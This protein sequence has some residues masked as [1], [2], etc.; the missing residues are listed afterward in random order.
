MIKYEWIIHDLIDFFPIC[1]NLKDLLRKTSQE[2]EKEEAGKCYYMEPPHHISINYLPFA[3]QQWPREACVLLLKQREK[4]KISLKSGKTPISLSGIR[5]SFMRTLGFKDASPVILLV[6]TRKKYL[7]WAAIKG[8]SQCKHSAR[9]LIDG[10][11]SACSAHPFP[12]S[13]ELQVPLSCDCTQ[14]R[15]WCSL[16]TVE[17]DVAWGM[18]NPCS[19]QKGGGM[20]QKLW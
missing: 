5:I 18:W 2:E 3:Q 9:H 8:C 6:Q 7:L 1:E 15:G 19:S 11:T 16:G 12:A 20:I 14:S 17:G 10:S 13:Q 4:P